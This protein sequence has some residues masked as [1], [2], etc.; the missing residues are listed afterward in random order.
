MMKKE[1]LEA[2]AGS[3]NHLH[4]A[5]WLLGTSMA[6]SQHRGGLTSSG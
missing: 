1:G 2:K 3:A 6:W 5:G 4:P